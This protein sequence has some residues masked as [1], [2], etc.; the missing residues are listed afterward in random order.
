M[1]HIESVVKIYTTNDYS[2]FNMVL[3]NRELKE[4]KIKRIR[5]DITNGLDILRL[6]PII[7]SE[8]GNKL[9]I[10]DGQHRYFVARQIK[11]H[12]FYVISKEM[13]LGDVAKI[14]S[15]QEKW[16]SKDFI[17]CYAV[18]GNDNY[19]KLQEFMDQYK[20]S[21]SVS[22]GLLSIGL[23]IGDHGV[24]EE[25]KTKFERGG[26][27]TTNRLTAIEVA[28]IVEQFSEFKQ[29]KTRLFIVA[30]CKLLKAEK[31]DMV[32]LVNKFKKDPEVLKEQSNYQNYLLNLEQIYNKGIH[33]R[34]VIY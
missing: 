27:E 9:N 23:A 15:N 24:Q 34:R 13:P 16:S 28:D 8:S 6:C 33:N 3:G 4:A 5:R 2:R 26:F 1:Q 10:I 17:H 29:N 21:V 25:M 7:V 18:Q 30:I 31:C 12:V 19:V 20:I 14:N 22:M 32:E 11:S